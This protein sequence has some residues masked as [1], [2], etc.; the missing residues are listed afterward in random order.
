MKDNLD[1]PDNFE[2]RIRTVIDWSEEGPGQ[3]NFL[4][5]VTDELSQELKKFL[6]EKGYEI[7]HFDDLDKDGEKDK[8]Q[9]ILIEAQSY[10]NHKTK[11]KV[12]IIVS[13]KARSQVGADQNTQA[14]WR[15]HS[16]Y[17]TSI[18]D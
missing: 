9:R 12:A 11:N 2:D 17:L 7:V 6:E 10:M 16:Q 14:E 13:K 8:L 4:R 18:E 5:I 3:H 15:L 1:R